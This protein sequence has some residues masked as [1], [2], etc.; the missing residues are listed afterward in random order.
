MQNDYNNDALRAHCLHN[1]GYLRGL[2]YE[3][4][5]DFADLEKAIT[6]MT[7]FLSLVPTNAPE[8]LAPWRS[9]IAPESIGGVYGHNAMGSNPSASPPV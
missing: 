6:S 8:R 1:L 7:D 9:G 2:R 3:I 5:P 4:S